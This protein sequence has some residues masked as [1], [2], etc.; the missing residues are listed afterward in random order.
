[1]RQRKHRNPAP[2]ANPAAALLKLA[3]A[4]DD[5]IAAVPLRLA[6]ER[7]AAERRERAA[8]ANAAAPGPP[9][10]YESAG[11]GI[12]PFASI[13]AAARAAELLA[14]PPLPDGE[15]AGAPPIVHRGIDYRY[16]GRGKRRLPPLPPAEVI[17]ERL[18]FRK[19]GGGWRGPHLCG[20]D[21]AG[22]RIPLNAGYALYQ[23]KQGAAVKCHYGCAARDAYAA[24]RNALGMNGADWTA[25][26]DDDAAPAPPK[27]KRGLPP[28]TAAE[29]RRYARR[30]AKHFQRPPAG[31]TLIAGTG[32]PLLL[33]PNLTGKQRLAAIPGE[34]I[35]WH[36]YTLADGT[37]DFVFRRFGQPG[38]GGA[39]KS[40]WTSKPEGAPPRPHS[41][42][43]PD[44]F[45]VDANPILAIVAEGEQAAWA[46]ATAGLGVIAFSA[47]ATSGMAGLNLD[48]VK[49]TGLPI[50]IAPDF[51]ANGAGARAAQALYRKELEAGAPADRLR[52]IPLDIVARAALNHEVAP[53]DLP[54]IDAADLTPACLAEII[55]ETLAQPEKPAKTHQESGLTSVGFSTAFSLP[56][57]VRPPELHCRNR[58]RMHYKNDAG[59]DGE[60]YID[61]GECAECRDFVR[62][63]HTQLY[64]AVMGAGELATR[65]DYPG[66]DADDARRFVAALHQ[67]IRRQAQAGDDAPPPIVQIRR[68]LAPASAAAP[69]DDDAA[70]DDGR[71]AEY[72]RELA[73]AAAPAPPVAAADD[74][75]AAPPDDLAAWRRRRA[76][77]AAIAR[78]QWAAAGKAQGYAG[79]LVTVIVKG[80]LPGNAEALTLKDMARRGKGTLRIGPLDKDEFHGLLPFEVMHRGDGAGNALRGVVWTRWPAR[81]DDDG[82]PVY[83][84][85]DCYLDR[86]SP[87]PP[88]GVESPE[89]ELTKER[90]E[91]G[92]EVAAA[93][94]AEGWRSRMGQGIVQ[95][96][97]DALLG[98]AA[99]LRVAGRIAAQSRLIAK[100][101]AAAANGL[102]GAQGRAGITR[103]LALAGVKGR[104]A[105]W[106][107]G[108]TRRRRLSLAGCRRRRDGVVQRIREITGYAGPRSLVA[109][110]ALGQRLCHLIIRND[111]GRPPAPL[112][113]VAAAADDAAAPAGMVNDDDAGQS[114]QR[115]AAG[116]G[117]QPPRR[118]A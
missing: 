12:D 74:D 29:W 88:P 86:K 61:C 98:W 43:L 110:S 51:D 3:Q 52:V 107:A 46:W 104:R 105:E 17:A 20:G 72:L 77:Q 116:M 54:G 42:L 109:D 93:L 8:A 37:R 67:R 63:R 44:R 15:R 89:T 90:R 21:S 56:P 18:G 49:A 26:A 108:I 22:A 75:D 47:N 117:K 111:V 31:Q 92:P 11:A 81:W 94:N 103:R 91:L 41:G 65:I 4:Q 76:E 10:G 68:E 96:D 70:P 112:A 99:A 79:A 25:A 101:V 62:L 7:A 84:M 13:R 55:A 48:D 16:A 2:P 32:W 39:P 106:R 34:W 71:N 102:I 58:S 28:P 64:Q 5:A 115:A 113:P 30:N 36:G 24:L 1:M 118:M 78:W 27:G 66:A 97:W 6:R 50:L 95:D 100:A 69:D 73:A 80:R 33:D 60:L 23:G 38:N 53:A 87:P 45:Q 35:A 14:P 40:F 82:P 85:A 83:G 114:G 59:D 57:P 19:V 9:E